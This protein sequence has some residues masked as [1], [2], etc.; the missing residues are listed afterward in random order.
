MESI[1]SLLLGIQVKSNKNGLL[2]F[3]LDE[4]I[5][6]LKTCFLE[7]SFGKIL[8]ILMKA[9]DLTICEKLIGKEKDPH[10]MLENLNHKACCENP[11][12]VK[13]RE[14]KR[15]IAS[16]LCKLELLGAR[17]RCE[18]CKK[19]F[20]PLFVFLGLERYQN[21]TNEFKKI[22]FEM[23]IDQS[24]RRGKKQLDQLTGS[25]LSLGQLW[26][27][28]MLDKKFA[29]KISKKDIKTGEFWRLMDIEIKAKIAK[30]PLHSILADGTCFKLQKAPVDIKRE[31]KKLKKKQKAEKNGTENTL[32]NE[33]DSKFS[34][35]ARPLQ[36]EVRI[37][38]GITKKEETIPLGVYTDKE[39]WR[40]IGRDIYKRFG[41]HP[42]LKKEP[43][44]EVLVADGEEA[45]F[46]GLGKLTRTQQRCQWHFNHEFKAVF[47]YGDKGSK[48]DRIKYQGQIQ[49]IMD[50]LHE[51]IL[52]E[53]NPSEQRKLELEAEIFKSE[54]Q[55]D[56]LA[57]KL[58]ET[59]NE[60]SETYVR[61]A[62]NKLFTYLK[63]HLRLEHLGPKV[64]SL[65]ERFMRE[66]GRRIK[67]IAWNWSAKGAATLCYI[68]LIRQ[69]NNDLWENYWKKILNVTGNLKVMPEGAFIKKQE[70]SLLQ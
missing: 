13:V 63:H 37:I 58:H 24:Y 38:Y 32:E 26:R 20:V 17:I 47:Q 5:L 6:G 43:I 15:S 65:L 7:W 12:F 2:P 9:V 60:E 1:L 33:P 49:T 25:V 62:T 36:S 30:D 35:K 4:S 52:K 22:V 19:S 48:E 34:D 28:V 14:D 57:D 54:I 27:T 56:K 40:Y 69:M 44:A 3:S 45:L 8:Q 64:T 55:L 31:M 61:N 18:V 39:S 46:E 23:V 42:K 16:S 70:P 53:T 41:K 21:K 67:K 68:I 10:G 59:N 29:L 11:W 50:E 66:I 51:K